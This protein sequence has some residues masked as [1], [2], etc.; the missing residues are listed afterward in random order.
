MNSNG[1]DKRFACP[2][3]CG[4]DF[5]SN[6][7]AHAHAVHCKYEPAPALIA[8]AAEI[9]REV[10]A[11]ME[12]AIED[13]AD[14]L[15][16]ELDAQAVEAEAEAAA[17]P[18]LTE[19]EMAIYNRVAGI[20]GAQVGD[21]IA[22]LQGRVQESL[23]IGLPQ[24]I[25]TKVD[26]GIAAFVEKLKNPAQPA[27][28]GDPG[29]AVATTATAG[30][31]KGASGLGDLMALVDQ[32]N[33]LIETPIGKLIYKKLFGGGGAAPKGNINQWRQGTNLAVR[34]LSANKS[35]A[36]ATA[37]TIREFAAP[38]KNKP[39][40]DLIRGLLDAA[41]MFV[42]T[43]KGGPTTVEPSEVKDVPKT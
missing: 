1:D 10:D 22:K 36:V 14:K 42:P 30:N 18:E 34:M 12:A 40:N 8:E 16:K 39:G 11:A 41:E 27:A 31:G 3:G 23:I 35:D 32:A 28:E 17:E 2:K 9:N 26:E 5:K 38:Y 20:V 4:R 6:S 25:E 7:G 19:S 24:M 13:G 21:E 43:T 29:T 33:Q 15:E 37:K